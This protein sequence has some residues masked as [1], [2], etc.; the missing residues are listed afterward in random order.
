MVKINVNYDA[1]QGHYVPN[2]DDKLGCLSK[3]LGIYSDIPGWV[4]SETFSTVVDAICKVS[5]SLNYSSG[6]QG[7]CNPSK[8]TKGLETVSLG[9]ELIYAVISTPKEV[10]SGVHDLWYG[11][12]N[13]RIDAVASLLGEV[14]NFCGAVKFFHQIEAVNMTRLVV[15]V[16]IVKYS[17]G[18]LACAIK[19]Y[20]AWNKNAQSASSPDSKEMHQARITARRCSYLSNGS[21]GML[22]GALLVSKRVQITPYIIIGLGLMTSA[23][24]VATHITTAQADHAEEEYAARNISPAA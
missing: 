2:R 18:L 20:S 5:E 7:V 19:I 17:T 10:L 13:E 3:P 14:S 11:S 12:G 8:L 23:T 6:L 9:G 1:A 21:L 4:V 15:G 16:E 24:F 22:F